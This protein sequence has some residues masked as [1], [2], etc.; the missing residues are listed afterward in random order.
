MDNVTGY[1]LLASDSPLDSS[2]DIKYGLGD[3]CSKQ[4][5]SLP[6]VIPAVE[7]D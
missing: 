7:R 5:V 1:T 4:C 6:E 2:E 3:S